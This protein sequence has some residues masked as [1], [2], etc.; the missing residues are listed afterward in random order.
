MN[1]IICGNH[2]DILAQLPDDSIDL[3]LTSPPYDDLRDYK[4]YKFDYKKLAPLLLQKTKEGGVVVWVVN[5][6]T[7]DGDETG[8][9]FR[10]ALYFKKV[11]FKLYDTMI[12]EKKNP[13]GVTKG[14]KY[15]S[16]FEYMF[17]FSKDIPKT[18][19]P[20]K[21]EIIHKHLKYKSST[22]RQKDGTTKKRKNPIPNPYKLRK[23][24]WTYKIGTPSTKDKIAFKHPAIFP[25]PLARDHIYSWTN[26]GDVVLDPMC[27]S[28]TTCKMAYVMNRQY[29]GIDMSEEYCN[30]AR[31]RIEA[32]EGKQKP[33]H[34]WDR[35]LNPETREK[36]DLFSFIEK[37]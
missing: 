11:G 29:I 18:F 2:L 36:V 25:E 13:V 32:N 30:I 15:T 27:G 10:Q 37:E 24:I 20:I 14:R 5:D 33:Q 7:E 9:S 31:T 3:T 17:V 4:G 8:T 28:G 6:K 26:E 35:K 19:N 22:Y 16:A 12:F 1:R 34:Y 21:K 23:N